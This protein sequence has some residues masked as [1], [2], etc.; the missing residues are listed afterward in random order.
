MTPGRGEKDLQASLASDPATAFQGDATADRQH[1]HDAPDGAAEEKAHTNRAW[2]QIGRD[3]DARDR[4]S[5]HEVVAGT[6]D[7]PERGVI[8]L[9]K[10]MPLGRRD[11][12]GRE[13]RDRP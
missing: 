7:P 6:S 9:A 12:V 3:N 10:A 11:K 2:Q 8:Q 1:D 5:E 4:G 13:K